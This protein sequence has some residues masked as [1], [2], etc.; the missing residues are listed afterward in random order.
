M[1]MGETVRAGL[2][3]RQRAQR[4]EMILET[5]F[6]LIA[7]K[8]YEAMT[9]DE[10]AERAGISK[11]T[12]YH[13]FASKEDIAARALIM[14]LTRGVETVGGIDPTL[15]PLA[16]LERVV[17]LLVAECL[18]PN[19]CVSA[20]VKPAM[21]HALKTRP[22]CRAAYDRLIGV[23]AEVVEQARA[24]GQINARLDSRLVTYLLF[25]LLHGEEYRELIAGGTV[26]PEQI[27]H[28]LTTVVFHGIG[29]KSQEK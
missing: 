9:M 8:S 4:D 14:L 27:A 10:L 23:V 19:L 5:A 12:L 7:E 13:H 6:A 3:E 28:T 22:D 11:P 15:P 29:A 26:S 2:R 17:E 16:R 1:D 25:S 18:Q 24:A 20:Q 21:T